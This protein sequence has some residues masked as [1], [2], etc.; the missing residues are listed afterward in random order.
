MFRTCNNNWS[1]PGNKGGKPAVARICEQQFWR[2][3][4]DCRRIFMHLL[5]FPESE[6]NS[7]SHVGSIHKHRSRILATTYLTVATVNTRDSTWSTAARYRVLMDRYTPVF[8][9]CASGFFSRMAVGA[10]E[11]ETR[12][13]TSTLGRPAAGP[14]AGVIA[15]ATGVGHSAESC[16]A[17]SKRMAK[18]SQQRLPSAKPSRHPAPNCEYDVRADPAR[19]LRH[20][21]KS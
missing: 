18:G 6:Q 20:S 11:A 17:R 4:L 16:F 19:R 21:S 12:H 10:S 3:P 13:L 2:C 9:G 14:T 5:P 7:N 1:W 8:V 15:H